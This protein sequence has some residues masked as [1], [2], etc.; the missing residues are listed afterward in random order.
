LIV[1]GAAATPHVSS[2]PGARNTDTGEAE[3][4]EALTEFAR[5]LP[6]KAE[7]A[8][9]T[10]RYGTSMERAESS[11][12]ALAVSGRPGSVGDIEAGGAFV[13]PRWLAAFTGNMVLMV[14]VGAQN[15]NGKW[16]VPPA[17][18]MEAV[19]KHLA[20]DAVHTL[21]CRARGC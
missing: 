18:E 2:W 4:P 8:V 15:V 3:S 1:T 10:T 13:D 7:P 12:A 20:R 17:E 11:A 19:L 5:G 9:T 21:R 14:E 6:L 16:P